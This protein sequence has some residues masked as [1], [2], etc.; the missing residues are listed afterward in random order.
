MEKTG[1]KGRDPSNEGREK[2][3]CPIWGLSLILY[4]PAR[5]ARQSLDPLLILSIKNFSRYPQTPLS[6][7]D[8]AGRGHR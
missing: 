7:S 1:Q 4:C 5:D 8:R 2:M 6:V 3:E